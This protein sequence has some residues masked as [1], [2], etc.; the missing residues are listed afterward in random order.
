MNIKTILEQN[1]YKVLNHDEQN[2]KF[3]VQDIENQE[4]W[5]KVESVEFN[6]N[7]DLAV[8]IDKFPKEYEKG[9]WD[10]FEW[11]SKKQ[12]WENGRNEQENISIGLAV[13][14]AKLE[15]AT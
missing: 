8:S 1:D 13:K 10:V 14:R 4:Y 11:D 9:I 3:K 12:V 5:V 7:G 2:E 15:S 6:K